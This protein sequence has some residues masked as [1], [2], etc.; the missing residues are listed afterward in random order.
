MHSAGNTRR[1][2]Q[3]D[4][5]LASRAQFSTFRTESSRVARNSD[6]L[7]LLNRPMPLNSDKLPEPV[8][9]DENDPAG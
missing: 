4:W 5:R 6:I 8:I 1:Q 7:D 2:A 9:A 3:E